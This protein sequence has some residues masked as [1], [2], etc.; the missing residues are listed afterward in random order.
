MTKIVHVES[1]V[2]K[3]IFLR[4]EKVLLDRDLAELYGVTT[5]NLNKAVKRNIERFP[6][7]FMFRLTKEEYKILRFQF[8]I[9]EKGKHSKYLPNAFTEQGV[10]M[11]SSVLRSKR[12]I[13]VNIA[14]MRAFV[15]LRKKIASNDELAHKLAE[16]ERHL[17][18]HDEQI[19]AIFEAIRQLML[20]P[21]KSQKKIGFEVKEAAAPYSKR[22]RRKRA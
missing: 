14:I 16:L 13:E 22:G 17:R 10:A 21:E 11:L 8:G 15:Y 2:S 9:I 7:D 3:I 12:A 1:I 5:G 18:D 20:P 4:D 19:Q 6:D